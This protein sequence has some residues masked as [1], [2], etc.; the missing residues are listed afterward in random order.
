LYLVLCSLLSTSGSSS[1][2]HSRPEAKNKEP[3][4]EPRPKA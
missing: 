1:N 4:T 2:R 3:R